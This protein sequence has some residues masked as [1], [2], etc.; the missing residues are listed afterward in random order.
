MNIVIEN[1]EATFSAPFTTN[2]PTVDVVLSNHMTP[3][4]VT[5]T[6]STAGGTLPKPLSAYNFF[7]N[8]II[9]LGGGSYRVVVGISADDDA[10]TGSGVNCPSI[11]VTAMS[12][13]P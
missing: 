5:V 6:P 1:Q 3:P 10:I 7:I 11:L 9:S 12:T 8:D 4:I 2:P 13:S